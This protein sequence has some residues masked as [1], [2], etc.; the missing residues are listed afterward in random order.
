MPS[1]GRLQPVKPGQLRPTAHTVAKAR[2]ITVAAR[3]DAFADLTS[4]DIEDDDKYVSDSSA[5]RRAM[6]RG[7]H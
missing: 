5:T 3:P 7:L 2:G 1:I 6:T 4:I